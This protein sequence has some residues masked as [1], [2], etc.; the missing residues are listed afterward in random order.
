MQEILDRFQMKDC[1]LVSILTEFGLKLNKN[2]G[3]KKVDSTLYKQII[4][5]L[6]HLTATKLDIMHYMSLISRYIEHLTEIHMSTVNRIFRYLQ[7]TKDFGLFYKKGK[8]LYLFRLTGSDYAED[9][10]DR[11]R[12]SGYD[13]MLGT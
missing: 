6:M 1:N 12:T 3:G 5:N 11:K 4:D 10:D 8:R 9:Q 2:H 13:F 7:G